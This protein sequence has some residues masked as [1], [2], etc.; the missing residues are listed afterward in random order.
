MR[1][2][3]DTLWNVDPYMY[4]MV[5]SNHWLWRLQ[6]DCSDYNLIA[7]LFCNSNQS[8]QSNCN[9]EGL[10]SDCWDCNLIAEIAVWL[11]SLHSD[12]W[13]CSLIAEIAVWLLRWLSDCWDCSLILEVSQNRRTW[14]RGF[15]LVES[16]KLR[17]L[18]GWEDRIKKFTSLA[19]CSE[20]SLVPLISNGNLHNQTVI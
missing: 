15:P 5:K 4:D 3:L 14:N 11:L 19:F 9:Q 17:P 20:I 1:W 10:Q 12:R 18:I 8:V 6:S 13:D 16:P 7:V 2:V